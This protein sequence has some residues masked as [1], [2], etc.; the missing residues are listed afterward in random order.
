MLKRQKRKTGSL[1][2]A[3]GVRG[4]AEKNA[5]E[6][7]S[8]NPCVDF[9]GGKRSKAI[10]EGKLLFRLGPLNQ[11]AESGGERGKSEMS[12]VAGGCCVWGGWGGGGF[13]T[14]E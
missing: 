11:G 12:R 3:G 9:K 6:G 13:K 2:G 10:E 14:S 1:K 7:T 5:R 8:L 4:G